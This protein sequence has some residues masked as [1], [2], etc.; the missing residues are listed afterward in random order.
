MSTVYAVYH[1][2]W[3]F[4]RY[5]HFL[6]LTNV[7]EQQLC[8]DVR[9]DFR[10]EYWDTETVFS[11]CVQI[12]VFVCRSISKWI[13]VDANWHVGCDENKCFWFAGTVAIVFLFS[14]HCIVQH[15]NRMCVELQ[16]DE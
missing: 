10:Q 9:L 7:V 5:L 13:E 2:C 8:I 6:Q 4:I 1:R 15:R 16:K 14:K 12:A 11:M 3:F